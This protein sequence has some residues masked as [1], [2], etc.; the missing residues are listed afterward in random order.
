M[1]SFADLPTEIESIIFEFLADDKEA[2]YSS[3]RVSQTWHNHTVDLL[4]Q[5]SS[6][7]DLAMIEEL[8]RQHYANKVVK[9]EVKSSWCFSRFR[10]LSFPALFEVNLGADYI[11]DYRPRLGTVRISSFLQPTLKKLHLREL[12]VLT[13]DVMDLI[14]LRCPLLE[15][16]E[17]ASELSFIHP[18]KYLLH[19]SFNFPKLRRLVY[20][21]GSLTSRSAL[22]RLSEQLP[23]LEYLDPGYQDFDLREEL[24][25]VVFP[26]LSTLKLQCRPHRTNPDFDLNYKGTIAVDH[27]SAILHLAPK[28]ETFSLGW[29]KLNHEFF[30][31]EMDVNELRSLR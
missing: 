24:V 11:P 22:R 13:E 30:R 31:E 17:L 16:L 25:G 12:F 4:W 9:L 10:F 1:P 3:I 18:E 6:A 7:D 23:L 26:R 29:F 27:L 28:L 20:R 14:C 15:E 19:S 21:W 5:H 8:R 2:L